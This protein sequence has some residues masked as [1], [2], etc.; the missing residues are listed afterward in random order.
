M[1]FG[2]IFLYEFFVFTNFFFRRFY[3]KHKLRLEEYAF[4]I[5]HKL[6]GRY[7]EVA[8]TECKWSDE[9]QLTNVSSVNENTSF[10]NGIWRTMQ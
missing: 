1:N 9:L 2:D 4:G 8:F 10:I 7:R 3:N 6:V 5:L